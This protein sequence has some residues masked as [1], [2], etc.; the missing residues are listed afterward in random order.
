MRLVLWGYYGVNYGDDM[1]MK[2]LLQYYFQKKVKVTLVDLY[3]GGMLKHRYCNFKDNT[4]F[5]E[6]YRYSKIEKLRF[7]RKISSKSKYINIWGGGTIF[8]DEDGDGNFSYFSIIKMLGGSIGYIGV[9]IGHLKKKK[10]IIKTAWL[11]KRSSLITF[12]DSSSLIRAKQ[13]VGDLNQFHLVED[14]VYYYVFNNTIKPIRLEDETS[15]YILITW[16]NL[17]NYI[18]FES[19]SKLMDE[20]VHSIVKREPSSKV[21]L[22]ALD[23]NHDVTSCRILHGKLKQFRVNVVFDINNDIDHITKLI[24][25]ADF[26]I[27]GR[28]HGSM[29]SELMGTK[30]ISLNYSPKMDYFYKSV[31]SDSYISIYESNFHNQLT[32]KLKDIHSVTIDL[33]N[34]SD[35]A[36]L[37]FKYLDQLLDSQNF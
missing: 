27:S 30:T 3:S 13:L 6:I 28:L 29:I 11:L 34:K 9:G 16:R 37:N 8:T 15:N 25:N 22:S 32:E 17:H 14:L 36:L 7:L 19:E 21:V 23:I 20:I 24:K 1:M 10:R 31:G 33:K 2:S 26:H 4:E 18:S 12:R 35:N 5:I